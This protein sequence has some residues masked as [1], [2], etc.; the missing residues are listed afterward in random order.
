MRKLIIILGIVM[1]LLGAGGLG[2]WYVHAAGQ[3]GP[4]LRTEEVKRG[5]LLATISASGTVEPVDVVDVGTQVT[6]QLIEFGQDNQASALVYAD[7]IASTLGLMASPMGQGPFLA[8]YPILLAKPKPV[9]YG[10]TVHPGT[11]LAKID[12][13]IY[14]AK[15]SQSEASLA[16]ANAKVKEAEANVKVAEANLSLAKAKDDQ[17]VRDWERAKVLLPQKSIAQADYDAFESAYFVNKAGLAVSQATVVQ[18]KES[19]A[20]AQAAAKFAE[21]FLKQDKINLAYCE[22]KSTV[23]GKIID[24]RVTLGQTVQSSFSTPSLF[25]LALDLSKMTVWASVNE[26]DVGQVKEGQTVRFTVDAHPDELFVG[27]VGKI[28]LNATMTQNVVTYTVEVVTDNSSGRLLPYLTANLHFEVD[29]REHVL[30]VSNEA[31]RWRPDVSQVVPDARD[32]YQ[33]YL[34]GKSEDPAG[35]D[36]ASPGDAKP[37]AEGKSK[38]KGQHWGVVWVQEGKLVRPIKVRIGLTDGAKTEV[39]EGNLEEGATIISGDAP[40]NGSGDGATNPFAPQMFGT[41]KS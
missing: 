29:K 9:D 2:V 38:K 7:A 23:E 41:K 40:Q 21:A 14:Q 36:G 3:S 19:V 8:A 25:L 39:L 24:R 32:N 20:D 30:L 11:L 34:R 4:T 6:G 1:A 17:S 13:S 28:R 12:P 22:I 10:S 26:A 16:Q 18:A 37:K 33:K 35:G 31:L 15:V 27:T 5:D